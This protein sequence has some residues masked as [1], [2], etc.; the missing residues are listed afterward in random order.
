MS[1]RAGITTILSIATAG[2]LLAVI[3]AA[4]AAVP[5]D[6][7]AVLGLAC[8][9]LAIAAS[10]ELVR[11]RAVTAMLAGHAITAAAM[12]SAI[13]PNLP[14]VIPLV[15]LALAA[16]LGVAS[17]VTIRRRAIPAH[18]PRPLV[19]TPRVAAVALVIQAGLQLWI[20]SAPALAMP[21]RA[22]VF[23]VLAALGTALLAS[24]SIITLHLRRAWVIAGL[25]AWTLGW[26]ASTADLGPLFL[27]ALG[28][29]Y[30]IGLHQL[31][32]L[33]AELVQIL[34]T[35]GGL[36][37]GAALIAAIREPRYRH[38]AMILLLSAA[39]FGVIAAVGEHRIE[40]ATNLSAIV[41]LRK[42][43]DFAAAISSAALAGVLWTYWRRAVEVCQQS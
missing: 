36:A 13:S 11:T 30:P 37:I 6:N 29:P 32:G 40:L 10:T 7:A 24:L 21:L 38:S 17:L 43:R 8:S 9:T 12:L 5:L 28:A 34:A 16:A 14:S 23:L 31:R 4:T 41:P 27:W 15:A 22:A 20:A 18:P 35:L 33:D 42:E 19:L 39:V 1:E 3:A 2:H 25:L 26:V